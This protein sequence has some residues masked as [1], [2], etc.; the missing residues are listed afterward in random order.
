MPRYLKY[1][2]IE[3]TLV[4]ALIHCKLENLKKANRISIICGTHNGNRSRFSHII[5]LVIILLVNIDICVILV[6]N[7]M[8][9]YHCVFLHFSDLYYSQKHDIFPRL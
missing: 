2:N 1:W 7:R 3:G 6:K 9:K 5:R 4:K 8:R